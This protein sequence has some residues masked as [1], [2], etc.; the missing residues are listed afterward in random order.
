M[1]EDEVFHTRRHHMVLKHAILHI[2]SK[3]FSLTSEPK[4][5]KNFWIVVVSYFL[6]GF[7]NERVGHVSG[8]AKA[9]GQQ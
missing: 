5:V 2:L 4:A 8:G 3:G 7:K 9:C 1:P 6:C